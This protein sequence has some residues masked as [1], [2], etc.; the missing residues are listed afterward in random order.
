MVEPVDS[1]QAAAQMRLW[2][3]VRLTLHSVELTVIFNLSIIY[4]KWCGRKQRQREGGD[5]SHSLDE[6]FR[7]LLSNLL[8][9]PIKKLTLKSSRE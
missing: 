4:I 5:S 8:R 1:P 2:L 3:S 6:T 7:L 9:R